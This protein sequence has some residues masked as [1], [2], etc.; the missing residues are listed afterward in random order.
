MNILSLRQQKKLIL[1]EEDFGAFQVD[2]IATCSE[3]DYDWI[4]ATITKYG[5]FKYFVEALE[6]KGCPCQIIRIDAVR[7][8]YNN[9]S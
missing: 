4:C 1:F 2:Y 7:E 6:E 5:C 3:T 8:V 9:L